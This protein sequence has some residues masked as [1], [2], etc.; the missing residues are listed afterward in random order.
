MKSVAIRISDKTKE[1]IENMFEGKNFSEKAR[2]CFESDFINKKRIELRIKYHENQIKLLKEMLNENIFCEYNDLSKEEM[3]FLKDTLKM[4]DKAVED[5]PGF[6]GARYN[7]FVNAFHRRITFTDFK[8]K[9][10]E[11]K[12]GPSRSD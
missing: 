4:R 6:I 3:A 11:I 5:N 2:E 9:L 1:Y 10:E 8:L 12:D 7:Y